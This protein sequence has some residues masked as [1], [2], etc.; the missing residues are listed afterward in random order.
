MW[1]FEEVRFYQC[2]HDWRLQK[3]WLETF[4]STFSSM[5]ANGS[6]PQHKTFCVFVARSLI[7][8][9]PQIGS[10]VIFSS[11]DWFIGLRSIVQTFKRLSGK[12]RRPSFFSSFTSLSSQGGIFFV[13]AQL[14]G[15]PWNKTVMINTLEVMI[16]CLTIWSTK[17]RPSLLSGAPENWDRASPFST[18][19]ILC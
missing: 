15:L 7:N 4:S 18:N 13:K 1:N 14:Q 11:L 16:Q 5:S 10:E 8:K 19:K 6:I 2:V 17:W 3:T 9:W 12:H